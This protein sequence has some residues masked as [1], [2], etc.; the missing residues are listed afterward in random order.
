[1]GGT[2]VW[3]HVL[4]AVNAVVEHLGS[5]EPSYIIESGLYQDLAIILEKAP[6]LFSFSVSLSNDAIL[7]GLF[8]TE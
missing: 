5:E 2:V 6:S 7:W 8:A 1:M 3:S 4:V